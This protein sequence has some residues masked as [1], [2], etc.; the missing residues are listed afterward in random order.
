MEE[1][2][3]LERQRRWRS[4]GRGAQAAWVRSLVVGEGNAAL[5]CAWPVLVGV[6][7]A[8]L[9][10]HVRSSRTTRLG[11]RLRAQLSPVAPH[12]GPPGSGGR[13]RGAGRARACVSSK[14]SSGA[15][16]GGSGGGGRRAGRAD[17]PRGQRSEG[18]DH[19]GPGRAPRTS[20]ACAG[21]LGGLGPA[22]RTCQ[23]G[24]GWPDRGALGREEGGGTQNR[25]DRGGGA[26]SR[27]RG[28]DGREGEKPQ[29]RRRRLEEEEKAS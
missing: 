9:L 23:G 1:D 25:G 12:H 19:R 4:R 16:G 29:R 18:G 2:G 22:G 28:G 13:G 27:N 21:A 6:G 5:R 7:I 10:R 15:L 20:R 11:L 17:G 8:G 14:G 24:V 26:Q 3:P